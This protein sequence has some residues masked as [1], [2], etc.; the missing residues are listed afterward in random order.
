[1]LALALVGVLR[2]SV[3]E[4][5]L[6]TVAA[7]T[8]F[9]LALGPFCTSRP[10]PFTLDGEMLS[11]PCLLV[12]HY[13]PLLNGVRVPSRFTELL[14]FS[15]AVLA[16]YGLAAICA[17]LEAPRWRAALVGMLLV[18]GAVELAAAPFPV[19]SA[20]APRVYSES[21]R[22]ANPSRSWNSP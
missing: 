16:G 5:R 17:R 11:V 8:F 13:I 14:V 21:A 10:V 7:V 4:D 22:G 6:F 19:A 15:L 2:S 1:L 20:K 3:G 12:L 18:G 9:V